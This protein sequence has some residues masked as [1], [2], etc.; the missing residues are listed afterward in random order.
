MPCIRPL[1]VTDFFFE[2]VDDLPPI[3]DTGDIEHAPESYELDFSDGGFCWTRAELD[4]A[5]RLMRNRLFENDPELDDD[6]NIE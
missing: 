1:I 6:L 3:G 5:V 2:W 4:E